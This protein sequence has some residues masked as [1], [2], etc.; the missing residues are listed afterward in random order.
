MTR[1]SR[2][3]SDTLCGRCGATIPTGDPLTLTTL[4]KVQRALIRGVCCAGPAPPD[5]PARTVPQPRTKK[6]TPLIAAKPG[7]LR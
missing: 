5:L 6:F 3:V 2:A 4:D 7:W 1:W